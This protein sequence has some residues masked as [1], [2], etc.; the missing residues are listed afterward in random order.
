MF[1]D[2]EVNESQ[3]VTISITPISPAEPV[4]MTEQPNQCSIAK[5][6]KQFHGINELSGVLVPSGWGR[7]SKRDVSE[8]VS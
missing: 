6:R 4:S 8:D 1:D 3:S 2:A 5:S 7:P